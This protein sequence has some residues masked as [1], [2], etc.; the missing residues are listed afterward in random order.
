[1]KCSLCGFEF[2]EKDAKSS[3]SGC[4]LARGCELI[5]CPNCGFE[6]T[7]EPKWIKNLRETRRKEDEIDR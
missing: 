5:R 1:M 4:Y 2:N 7:P 6:M 3:C